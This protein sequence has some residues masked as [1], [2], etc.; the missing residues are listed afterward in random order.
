MKLYEVVQGSKGVDGLRKAERPDPKPGRG[1]VL[2]RVRAVSLNFRD[3]AVVLGVYP[4]PQASGGLIPLSDGA[5]EVL[6][7]G[8]GVTRFKPGDRVASTFFQTWIEG[9]PRP[10]PALGAG[11]VDGMFA[12]QV[13][14]HEDGLVG[15]PEWMSFEE[16][17]DAVLRRRD[18]VARPHGRG[19]A[20]QARADGARA[21]HR[22][23]CRSSRC[24]SRARRAPRC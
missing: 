10:T 6:A 12:Q 24:N 7:V 14:L 2:V 15:I 3:L 9:V 23:A 22:R 8:E 4:G 5:G 20:G 13:V 17:R 16:G 21:R 1:Q 19:R 11:Q 18:G